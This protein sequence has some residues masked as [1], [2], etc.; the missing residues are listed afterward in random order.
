MAD[1]HPLIARAVSGLEVDTAEN[2][3][4][5]YER[6]RTA[7]VTQLRSTVPPLEEAVITRERLALEEAIRKVEMES[8]R[9]ARMAS[10]PDVF[11]AKQ[12]VE[13]VRR[14]AEVAREETAQ[15]EADARR[16]EA[17][18]CEEQ[19]RR[20]E[21]AR[22]EEAAR[23]EEEVRR[24]A[25]DTQ[26]QEEIRRQEEM[27]HEE[28]M[29][30]AQAYQA[31][32]QSGTT[33]AVIPVATDGAVVGGTALLATTNPNIVPLPGRPEYDK[34][35]DDALAEFRRVHD[36]GG[37]KAGSVESM[38]TAAPAGREANAQRPPDAAADPLGEIAASAAA[39]LPAHLQRRAAV[40]HTREAVSVAGHVAEPYPEGLGRTPRA[41]RSYRRLVGA[42]LFIMVALGAGAVAY[43]QGDA[44]GN[45]AR[46]LIGSV[47]SPPAPTPQT[48]TPSR[49]KNTDRVGQP[50]LAP[51]AKIGAIGSPRAMLTTEPDPAN[52]SGRDFVGTANWQ[53]EHIPAAPGRPAEVAIRLEVE[54]PDRG[55]GMTWLVRRNTDPALPATHT[56]D[57][58][59]K[60][61]PNSPLGAISE[62]RSML[63][64]QPGQNDEGAPLW[65][66]AQKS[67]PTYFLVGLSATKADAEHNLRL[68][69]TQPA[70][71][72]LLV[73]SKSGRAF[74]LIEKGAV[75]EKVFAEAFAA[76]QQ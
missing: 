16:E 46:R 18:R 25:E 69:K 22:R 51:T 24:R 20:E 4:A 68:L 40:I 13:P 6:A 52:P 72:V 59:F 33:P 45:A 74:L 7:L 64:K 36:G 55:F 43:W 2:R 50:D 41:L 10:K 73:F 71:D 37:V 61:A 5:L 19:A 12:P 1:Y 48:A 30:R 29:F 60:I 47:Q 65:G 70:F 53:L 58:E 3:R 21:K 9:R 57:I 11:A 49:Q 75:G 39:G 62:I 67:T 34:R 44:I 76:W 54:I 56:I 14:D 15:H 66:H 42:G 35:V 32:Q 8:L 63:M 23:H 26:R 27:R 17:A 28:S 31:V 38:P